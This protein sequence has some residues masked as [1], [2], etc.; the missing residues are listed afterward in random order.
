MGEEVRLRAIGSRAD[1]R[2]RRWRGPAFGCE[3]DKVRRFPTEPGWRVGK[4]RRTIRC[5]V[6]SVGEGPFSLVRFFLGQQ[7]ERG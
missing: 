5:N 2:P 1:E 4:S 6:S 7:K 3:A